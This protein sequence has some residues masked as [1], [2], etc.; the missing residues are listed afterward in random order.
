MKPSLPRS[1]STHSRLSQSTASG[2]AQT[3]TSRL[4]RRNPSSTLPAT[5]EAETQ[6]AESKLRLPRPT[7]LYAR[8]ASNPPPSLAAPLN[9]PHPSR[10]GTSGGP[11]ATV[12]NLRRYSGGFAVDAGKEFSVVADDSMGTGEQQQLPPQQS[13]RLSVGAIGRSASLR[14]KEGFGR[15]K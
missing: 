2:P 6:S 1:F 10:S 5:K 9:V 13:K 4:F 11:T 14:I 15:K 3:F 8:T 7:S 12:S